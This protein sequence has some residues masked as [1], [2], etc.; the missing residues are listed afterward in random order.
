MQADMW[1]FFYR[2]GL[3][4]R[5]RCVAPLPVLKNPNFVSTIAVYSLGNG[6]RARIA[7]PVVRSKL[8]V[9]HQVLAYRRQRI[10]RRWGRAEVV[11]RPFV[12]MPS[13]LD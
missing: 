10:Y 5:I 3:L 1:W 7:G 8:P 11:D 2:E 6:V 12:E 9:L 4:D 13:R